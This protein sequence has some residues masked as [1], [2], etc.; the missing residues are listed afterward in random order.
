MRVK[1]EIE[2]KM[3][4]RFRVLWRIW[5][6]GLQFPMYSLEER[7]LVEEMTQKDCLRMANYNNSLQS[8]SFY[9][10]WTFFVIISSTNWDSITVVNSTDAYFFVL[11]HLSPCLRLPWIQFLKWSL[12]II[13]LMDID[14]LVIFIGSQ[15]NL[16]SLL[17]SITI[18]RIRIWNS[19]Y[20]HR[21][22]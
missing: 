2:E 4:Q 21:I 16:L 7:V 19:Y 15:Q 17:P 8:Y 9:Y 6:D 1:W 14:N 5:Q 22:E 10:L 20:R 12:E 13:L 11:T 3:E 18:T